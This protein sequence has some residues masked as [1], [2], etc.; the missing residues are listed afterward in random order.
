MLKAIAQ[1]RRP[2]GI[3]RSIPAPVMGWNTVDSIGGMD[4][5]YA[6]DMENWFPT[7]SDVM[8]RMGFSDQVTVIAGGQVQSLMAYS[9]PSGSSSLY[10][11]AGGAIYNCTQATATASVAVSGFP[12]A[13]AIWEHT[14]FTNTGGT[15]YLLCVNSANGLWSFDGT[16][17]AAQAIT[18]TTASAFSHVNMHK[19]RLWFCKDNTL[20]AYYLNTGAV[21]GTA[22]KLDLSGFCRL[23]GE[24][25]A[26][27]TWTL[28]AGEGMDDHWVAVTSNGEIIVYKGTD[29]TSAS[30][31]A[32]VGRWEVGKPLSRR[33]FAKYGGDL[34][35]HAEDGAWP[36]SGLLS[37]ERTK[38]TLAF[39]EK[40]ADAVKIAADSYRSNTGW[41]L[42]YWP[43]GTMVIINIPVTTGAR[44][45]QYVMNSITRAWCYFTGIS[46]N[47]F[48]VYQGNIY[49]GGNGFVSR[50]WNTF[51]DDGVAITG[52]VKQ[53]FHYFGNRS[54]KQF[55]LARPILS[56][57][58]SPATSFGVNVDFDNSDVLKD[59]S[60]SFITF[61]LWDSALW[62]SGMWGS[63]LIV[64]RN[65][66][67][68]S[69]L[70]FC[71]ACRIRAQS[72]GIET[73]WQS[74][75]IVFKPGGIL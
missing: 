25:M 19:N 47:C 68:V 13:N 49:Y 12:T 21:A 37:T 32:M 11:A 6:L 60:Y 31:W 36:L 10:A 46:A 62:D 20:E 72:N 1:R 48:E 23:G 2:E 7:P 69:G 56:T 71:A 35:Y 63:G 51:A 66:V 9:S 42:I 73:H 67:N 16:T 52:N 54:K 30:T 40:I 50:F 43:R 26:T 18:G 27:A 59:V 75:D 64:N 70:G 15:S 8:L 22:S 74:T 3:P 17:W 29:P 53:A 28:D 5:R 41:Q 33:C 57:N 38:P 55:V 45:R 34:I 14:N 61:G 39:S 44:Q 65:W 4:V 24:L 58:G